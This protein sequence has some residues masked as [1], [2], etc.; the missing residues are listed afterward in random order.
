VRVARGAAVVL[1][2]VLPFAVPA[3]AVAVPLLVLRRRRGRAA[4][5][6]QG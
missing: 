4:P 5:A 1:G 3:A 2:A 6:G